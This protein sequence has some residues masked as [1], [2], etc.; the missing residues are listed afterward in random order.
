MGH[1][2]QVLTHPDLLTHISDWDIQIKSH[3]QIFPE[4]Y[5]NH[6]AKSQILHE[7]ESVTGS[8]QSEI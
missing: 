8:R 1:G 5:V 7:N 3:T 2:S 6:L 4:K